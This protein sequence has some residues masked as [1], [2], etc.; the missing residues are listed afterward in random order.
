MAFTRHRI[1]V[2]GSINMDL[3]A[4]VER[5]PAPGQTVT[6]LSS[7]QRFG[8]K[9][10]NQAVAAVRQG[11]AVAMIGCVG[12]DA[13]GG[14]YRAHLR[15]QGI[16][17]A[18]IETIA[19]VVTGTAMIAVDEAAENQIIVVPGANGM[20]NASHVGRHEALIAAAD[21]V[22]LQWEVPQ[23]V[24][25]ETLRLAARHGAPVVMNPSP[26]H[27]SFPWGEHPLHTLI[28]NQ[29][30]AEAIFDWSTLNPIATLQQSLKIRGITRLVITRGARSTLGILDTSHVDVPTLAVEPVDTVGAG[31]SFAG[32]YAAC[33]ARG[34]DFS[35]SLRHANFAGA[36]ATRMPGAQESIPD[37][38]RVERALLLDGTQEERPNKT[39]PF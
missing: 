9:G 6:A 10:A 33:L 27:A 21:V 36:L 18:G 22:L 4:R 38:S 15:S 30:E 35:A 13:A 8:G 31:D 7:L 24:V 39:V 5:L 3:I 26:C 17:D 14:L 11:S 37:R 25:M 19:G 32:A 34:M 2:V 16:D 1:V 12:D 29:G 23:S 28:V 20:M